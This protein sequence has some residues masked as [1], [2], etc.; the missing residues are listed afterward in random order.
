MP[1]H[2]VGELPQPVA[3]VFDD[4]AAVVGVP[5]PS[6]IKPMFKSR[7]VAHRS[8]NPGATG[9]VPVYQMTGSSVSA[10]TEER[11]WDG[12]R[13]TDCPGWCPF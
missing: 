5:D 9:V 13:L 1:E 7:R 4:L 6:Q 11:K 8:A 2:L 10:T 3:S 12:N